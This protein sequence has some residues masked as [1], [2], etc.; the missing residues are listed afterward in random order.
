MPDSR[1]RHKGAG[2]DWDRGWEKQGGIE[3]GEA[4]IR[5]CCMKKKPYFQ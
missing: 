1:E 4:I 2:S 3:R 5:I